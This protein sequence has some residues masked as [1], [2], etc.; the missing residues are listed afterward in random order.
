MEDIGDRM[1]A[2]AIRSQDVPP[3]LPSSSGGK[4]HSE[5]AN[6]PCEI[7]VAIF[8]FLTNVRDVMSLA[9]TCKVMRIVFGRHKD[10][11]ALALLTKTLGT[12]GLARL[13]LV[14]YETKAPLPCQVWAPTPVA[15]EAQG[16]ASNSCHFCRLQ[17]IKALEDWSRELRLRPDSI[18]PPV[19][20]RRPYDAMK[21]T[22]RVLKHHY[23]VRLLA[24][25]VAF[26]DR[27]RRVPAH[28]ARAWQGGQGAWRGPFPGNMDASFDLDH[29]MAM[30][31]AYDILRNVLAIDSFGRHLDVR[32]SKEAIDARTDS[33]EY[34]GA[35][36]HVHK[37]LDILKKLDG[38]TDFEKG[39]FPFEGILLGAG[40]VAGTWVATFG[41]RQ[42][43]D[44]QGDLCI[45]FPE[46]PDNGRALRP[47]IRQQ[48]WVNGTLSLLGMAELQDDWHGWARRVSRW[49]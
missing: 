40:W 8:K 13:A 4:A 23:Y 48:M 28:V 30:L 34:P 36:V 41:H 47:L 43:A 29:L 10:A 9:S 21:A 31:Y 24:D 19:G 27:F 6:L 18:L 38:R 2:T 49:F 20:L 44:P 1:E 45:R 25:R 15:A 26:C 33:E 22:T 12:R 32:A 37:L 39:R 17:K 11:I 35:S 3:N 14:H 42:D 46:V 16:R 5:I 7:K